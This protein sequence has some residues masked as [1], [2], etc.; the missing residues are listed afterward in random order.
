M[1]RST[2]ILSVISALI[3]VS[4]FSV[5]AQRTDAFFDE[6]V[7]L[8]QELAVWEESNAAADFDDLLSQLDDMT[9]SL[10]WDV[11]D[12]DWFRPYVSSLADWE[13]V[14]G[15][16]DATGRSTGQFKPGNPVSIAEILKMALE[17]ADVDETTCYNAPTH[18]EA[19]NHWAKY[20]VSCAEQMGIRM[21]G[22]SP[23]SLSSSA[24]RGQVL[25][26][27]HD[28]FHEKV[29]P[30]YSN[31]KDTS[32]HLYETDI[33]H[34][35]FN[36]IV[37]GDTDN[38]GNPTGVFRPDDSINRAEVSKIIYEQLKLQTVREEVL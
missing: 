1:K 5:H 34:A 31:F 7:L 24:Q 21:F 30:L 19:A 20:Y 3:M 25:A 15:Y 17:A 12:A 38:N 29:L 37:S 27:V 18:P 36:G 22:T 28:A 4:L 6:V 11:T 13:I 35:A 14:S 33:A 16:K 8:K 23:I 32:N 10:F 26:I 2:T 9:G